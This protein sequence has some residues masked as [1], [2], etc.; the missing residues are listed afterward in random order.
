LWQEIVAKANGDGVMP[1][2]HRAAVRA[3]LDIHLRR[4]IEEA[5]GLVGEAA[6]YGAVVVAGVKALA[7]LHGIK[8]EEALPSGLSLEDVGREVR[9]VSPLIAGKLERLEKLGARVVATALR[10]GVS[11]TSPDIGV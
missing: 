3:Y 5:R 2:E 10:D 1:V 6:A 7:E 4:V 11:A 8:A 9:V